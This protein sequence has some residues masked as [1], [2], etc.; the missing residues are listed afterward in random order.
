MTVLGTRALRRSSRIAAL[1]GF[2]KQTK[3]ASSIESVG[4]KPSNEKK[5][6]SDEDIVGL[7]PRKSAPSGLSRSFEQQLWAKGFQAVAGVDEAGRGP[8]AGPVVAAACII[9]D[10]VNIVGIDDS[11]KLAAAERESLYAELTSHP[12]IIWAV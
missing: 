3:T 8:L 10:E 6:Q 1:D 12:D 2:D 9:P 4:K 5:R 7:P 11:K